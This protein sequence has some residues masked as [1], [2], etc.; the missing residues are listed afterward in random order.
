VFSLFSLLF[1]SI[2]ISF[3]V[4]SLL[5]FEIIVGSKPWT[6]TSP[7][8]DDVAITA[9]SGAKKTRTQVPELAA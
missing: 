7:T 4:S 9:G 1:Y 8:L 2:F 3:V 5:V 6:N